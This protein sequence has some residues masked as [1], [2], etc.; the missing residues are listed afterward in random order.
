MI[1]WVR[2]M[3]RILSMIVLICIAASLLGCV[4]AEMQHNQTSSGSGQVYDGFYFTVNVPDGWRIIDQWRI[5]RDMVIMG[6]GT[7]AVAVTVTKADDQTPDDFVDH[8]ISAMK[9]IHPGYAVTGREETTL[10]HNPGVKVTGSYTSGGAPVQV[11]GLYGIVDDMKIALTCASPEEIDT[12]L[13]QNIT[14]SVTLKKPDTTNAGTM[15]FW[16]HAN[17]AYSLSY[18]DILSLTEMSDED[19]ILLKNQA[20]HTVMKVR[21]VNSSKN[22]DAV[23]Q[24][25][26]E[27]MERENITVLDESRLNI[28]QNPAGFLMFEDPGAKKGALKGFEIY[29]PIGSMGN[30]QILSIVSAY[31]AETFDEIYPVLADIVNSV[32]IPA[33]SKDKYWYFDPYEYLFIDDWIEYGILTDYIDYGLDF[34]LWNYGYGLTFT[35]ADYLEN[36]LGWD[37]YYLYDS[38]TSAW[39]RE[40]DP[41]YIADLWSMDPDEYFQADHLVEVPYDDF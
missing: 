9:V 22:L 21:I 6:D 40:Y 37:N 7:S 17:G 32:R 23:M 39:Y 31:P 13:L 1:T 29:V 5:N 2:T 19:A 24:S 16:K 41:T 4:H 33:K 27:R 30:Q 12:T 34:D 36:M 28:D 10:L 8:E 18:P 3:N 14:D 20:N 15:A 11:T 35:D 38:D 25:V 26:R